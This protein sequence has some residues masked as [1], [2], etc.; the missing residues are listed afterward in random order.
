MPEQGQLD[1]REGE[2]GRGISLW[3]GSHRT[4][5]SLGESEGGLAKRKKNLNESRGEDLWGTGLP[6]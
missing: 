6:L 4:R 5:R 3:K 2:K 1:G